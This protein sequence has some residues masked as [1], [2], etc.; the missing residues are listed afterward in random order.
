MS[1]E[2][3]YFCFC[4]SNCKY[5]TMTKEQILAA[6]EQATGVANVNPDAGFITKIK[7]KNGGNYVTFWV[8]TQAEYNAIRIKDVN[9][10]YIISDDTAAEELQEYIKTAATG[11]IERI[12]NETGTLCVFYANGLAEAW[13]PY[14]LN[15]VPYTEAVGG[16]YAAPV[17]SIPY[18]DFL[19]SQLLEYPLICEVSVTGTE[20]EDAQVFMLKSGQY[21]DT[22]TAKFKLLCT[23]Q[24]TMK[25]NLLVHVLF[26]WKATTW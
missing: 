16:F 22:R 11:C 21:D 13:L 7:E 18:N 26:K 3:K 1:D 8:G 17:V 25:T 10:L 4:G 2:K 20:D 6:I 9:C 12:V 24:T 23:K 14:D 5:E 15:G 19:K